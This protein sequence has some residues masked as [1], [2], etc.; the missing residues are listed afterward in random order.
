MIKKCFLILFLFN[1]Y[2]LFA[3]YNEKTI[4]KDYNFDSIKDTLNTSY[5]GG[6]SFG[7]T[8]AKMINGKTNQSLEIDLFHAYASIK[9]MITIPN[10]YYNEENKFY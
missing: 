1:F 10:Y 4:I 8:Y 6:G 5:D 9:Y 3:Q 2:L 7:G